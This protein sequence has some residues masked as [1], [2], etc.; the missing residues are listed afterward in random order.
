MQEIADSCRFPTSQT[1]RRLWRTGT[2]HPNPTRQQG[3][4]EKEL[5]F[6]KA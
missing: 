5:R 4:Q 6:Q 3:P 1:E 2:H